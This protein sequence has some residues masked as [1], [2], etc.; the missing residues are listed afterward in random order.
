MLNT[1]SDSKT[2]NS[3]GKILEQVVRDSSYNVITHTHTHTHTAE[4]LIYWPQANDKT[5][6]LL[7][8]AITRR[9]KDN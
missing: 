6:D 5:P 4:E 3:R 9:I 7:D 2:A 1:T 8:F